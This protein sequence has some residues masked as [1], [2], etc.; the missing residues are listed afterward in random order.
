MALAISAA[1]E[2]VVLK[3][4]G[5]TARPLP[6]NTDPVDVAYLTDGTL[7]VN[8]R[9]YD[10]HHV[11]EIATFTSNGVRTDSAVVSAPHMVAIANKF[12]TV[13]NQLTTLDGQA[14]VS[15]SIPLGVTSNSFQPVTVRPIAVLSS[16]N[17]ALASSD[18][19]LFANV[20]SG[21]TMDLRL[22]SVSCYPSMIALPPGVTLLPSPATCFESPLLVAADA[23]GNV[24]IVVPDHTNE[25]GLL[26][27]IT[28]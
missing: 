11:D 19:V 6:A 14:Q 27:G 18:G 13:S 8:L 20:S 15:A 1:A 28:F 22:A 10:T 4:G 17:V 12:V 25:I 23:A 9:D 5:F 16:G 2:V 3:D 24:W 26:R 7:G 21:Q